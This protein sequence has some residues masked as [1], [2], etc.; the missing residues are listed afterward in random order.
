MSASEANMGLSRTTLKRNEVVLE[1]PCAVAE[2][3][4]ANGKKV[5][6]Y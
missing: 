6:C 4:I 5:V 2:W 1:N 3:V